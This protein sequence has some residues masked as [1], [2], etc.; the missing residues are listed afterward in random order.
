MPNGHKRKPRKSKAA[1]AAQAL[2]DQTAAQVKLIL[3][4]ILKDH[5]HLSLARDAL[6]ESEPQ[7]RFSTE[8]LQG[9]RMKLRS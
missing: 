5:P 1:L 9:F 3:D 6:R 4:G 2:E 7:N 8:F